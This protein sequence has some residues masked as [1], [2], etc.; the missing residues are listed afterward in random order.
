MSNVRKFIP[1]SEWLY[2]KIYTGIKVADVILEEAIEPLLKILSEKKLIEKWFFIRY[3]DPKPHLR[4]RFQ[5]KDNAH[6]GETLL[7]VKES[8]KNY[9]DSGEV[10]GFVQDIYKREIER[11]GEKT[12]E[13]AEFLFCKSS[14]FIIKQCLNLEDEEKII[15]ALFYMD[16]FLDRLHLCVEEK[17]SW[18]KESNEAFKMEFNADKKLNSQL[19]KKYRIFK[20]EYEEF[21]RSD[22]FID[23]KNLIRQNIEDSFFELQNFPS[24]TEAHKIQHIVQ[25]VFHMHINRMFISQQRLF[26]M[27]IYDYLYRY[28]K[29]VFFQNKQ[30]DNF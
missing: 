8:I 2:F 3:H 5:I 14:D 15:A 16:T 17:L 29:T 26:E 25:S 30:N 11:Y 21:L 18:V 19:D 20:P 9:I 4:I 27:I 22:D 1:G 24:K 12:I 6:Y 13:E 28:Y 23:F 10:A 7:L